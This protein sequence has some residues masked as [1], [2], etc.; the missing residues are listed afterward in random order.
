MTVKNKTNRI[1]LANIKKDIALIEFGFPIYF[2]K[3]YQELI[4]WKNE[5]YFNYVVK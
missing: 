5:G 1:R 4:K 2:Q 3:L